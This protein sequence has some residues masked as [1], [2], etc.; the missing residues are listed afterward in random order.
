M[1]SFAH[2]T[3][4]HERDAFA[5][6]SLA[7]LD[8]QTIELYPST[9]ISDTSRNVYHEC[10]LI[11]VAESF[12]AVVELKHWQGDVEVGD[13]VWRRGEAPIRDPHEVN[14][15]KAKVF[16]GI[17]EKALPAAT[18]PFV[19]SIVV[20]TGEASVKGADTAYEVLGR[21]QAN[22][23]RIGDHL[24]FDGVDELA[25]YLRVRVEKDRLA[26]RNVLRPQEFA[27]LRGILDQKFDVQGLRKSDFSDQISGF[28]IREELENTSRYVSYLAEIVPTRGDA[29]WRLRVFGPASQDEAER[30]RQYRSLDAL[31]KLPFH[32][33]I[34]PAHRH[35]NERNLVVEACQWTDVRTLDQVLRAGQKLSHRLAVQIARDVALALVHIHESNAS[36][37]HRS[38]N[39]RSIILGRD[40]HVE[41]V[42]F[43]LA[44]DPS[45][46]FTVMR[47]T[48][49]ADQAKYVAREV[50]AGHSD[51]SSDVYSLGIVLDE[52]LA[53]RQEINVEDDR[54]RDLVGRMSDDLPAKR[55]SAREVAEALSA[56]I[57][58]RLVTETAPNVAGPPK[59][60]DEYDT[61][62]LSEE[63][64]RG[65]TSVVFRADSHG[66]RAV[67]KVFGHDASRERCL[68]ERDFLRL[69]RSPFVVSFRS[70][71]QWAGSYW[72]IVQEHAP[73]KSLRRIIDSGTL[74]DPALFQE[75]ANQILQGLG[76][77]HTL[78]EEDGDSTAKPAIVHNDVTPGNIVLDPDR[79]VAKLIDFGLASSPGLGVIGGTPGYVSE[80]RITK[81]GY[82][83]EPAGDLYSLAVTLVEWATGKR[84]SSSSSIPLLFSGS[85][86][87]HQAEGLAE[88]LRRALGPR[89][90][91]FTAASE[92]STALNAA[93]DAVLPEAPSQ[94]EPNVDPVASV[95]D[96]VEPALET[97]VTAPLE[98]A[99]CAASN[100][101]EYLNTVHN[102]SANNR[103][104]LAEAQ[105]T[106]NYFVDLHVEM[107]L[108]NSIERALA[109]ERGAVVVLTGHAGDGK[110]TIAV[111]F[112]KKARGIAASQ[113]LAQPPQQE[114]RAEWMG[115]P[116]T[117][118]KDMSELPAA[119]RLAKLSESM[120]GVGSA[121]IVS[122]T[123]P[124]LSTFREYFKDHDHQQDQ[125]EQEVLRALDQPLPPG[126]L[127][128]DNSFRLHDGKTVYI[129]NL[130]ML[131]NVSTAV[132]LFDKLISHSAWSSC[133]G[134]PAA[135]RCP[136]R[137]NISVLQTQ[138][139][140][141]KERLGFVYE[142]LTAYGRRMSMRQLAAHLSF[143]LTAG[144]SCSDIRAGRLPPDESLIFSET[145]FGH[146]GARS[147]Q[148]VDALFCLTQMAD[149]HFGA[150]SSPEIDALVHQGQLLQVLMWPPQLSAIVEKWQS[151]AQG[152]EGG[153]SRRRLRRLA[154]MFATP[155]NRSDGLDRALLDDFLQSPML[156]KRAAWVASKNVG[157]GVEKQKFIR[158]AIGVLMEEFTGCMT[159]EGNWERLFLTVR[160]P[161]EQVF[162][163][164]QIVLKAIPLDDFDLKF[165]AQRLMPYLA[166]IGS[167]AR[168]RLSLPLLDYIIKRSRGELA[169]DLDA[170]HRAALEQFRGELLESRPNAP[171]VITIVEISNDG[172]L[173]THRFSSSEDGPRLVYQ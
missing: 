95:P 142:R 93:F 98:V 16:K 70:F 101:V 155:V 112:L 24:T 64:G 4:K 130:S 52:L 147:E 167:A 158:R 115:R 140:T 14:L 126:P 75:V 38:I 37:I 15:P 164:I 143:S 170:I 133:S 173:Q 96:A 99:D 80:D 56:T 166:H 43:D 141:A 128:P 154:F 55:P 49:P 12:A 62:V 7:P 171:D 81:E 168:L 36:L 21:L 148:A 61:W 94:L 11:V 60:G 18:A 102:V 90:L 104:A 92:M 34:R 53:A 152:D 9:Y 118:L 136:I 165:D 35:P 123:G 149:L 117:V 151:E 46:G 20:L 66:D 10:D 89:E 172:G 121:L 41:L 137:R 25:K 79:R 39:P 124:L 157:S 42:D 138:R 3:F 23:G 58:A 29:L 8:E 87:P 135:P 106:S 5:K 134:C 67:L 54:L 109:N 127:G 105:A 13:N 71:M 74:P 19:Q 86:A 100:F 162:Q 161:D 31:Q 32:P 159:P 146:A 145:F 59:V 26:R 40:D 2:C 84:P 107:E 85:L 111:E 156:R 17:I 27:R 119:T 44:F 77:L 28:K 50:L 114:E 153:E 65:A 113:P 103:H 163:S 129:A 33:N 131:G 132:R 110:S 160:R 63:L 51:Y 169:T 73:G 1:K 108:T 125:I 144:Y 72:C 6:L 91:A 120:Q 22:N 57:G 97:R 48:L 82:V 150:A 76:H 116:V 139:E 30:A 68:T 47:G 78:R 69:A 88:V 122:N 45:A 83:A